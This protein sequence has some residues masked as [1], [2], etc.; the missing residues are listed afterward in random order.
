MLCEGLLVSETC[1][2]PRMRLKLADVLHSTATKKEKK[3]RK[4]REAVSLT[5]Y[6]SGSFSAPPTE[7]RAKDFGAFAVVHGRAVPGLNLPL[8]E[9]R[10]DIYVAVKSNSQTSKAVTGE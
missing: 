3:G 5:G 8:A 10:G 2:E 6:S 4:K 1:A 7:R 9:R